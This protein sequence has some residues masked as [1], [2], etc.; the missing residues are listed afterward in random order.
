MMD[1]KR[2]QALKARNS[3]A[4]GEGCEAAETLGEKCRNEKPLKGFPNTQAFCPGL[5][6]AALS[7]LKTLIALPTAPQRG[8]S[9]S[10][11]FRWTYRWTV[12]C[13]STWMWTNLCFAGLACTEKEKNRFGRFS[14][15]NLQYLDSVIYIAVLQESYGPFVIGYK[16]FDALRVI[17]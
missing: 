17:F 11:G 12:A 6:C 7:A 16:L 5:C 14:V 15:Y 3:K 13:K 4:K 8:T 1:N 9:R 10:A 2:L